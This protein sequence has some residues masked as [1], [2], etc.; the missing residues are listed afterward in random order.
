[1]TLF[2]RWASGRTSS[3]GPIDWCDPQLILKP[4]GTLGVS[5]THHIV[6]SLWSAIL[7]LGFRIIS[8][9][10]WNRANATPNALHTAYHPRGLDAAYVPYAFS[11]A[12]LY[13]RRPSSTAQ[14]PA[15][16]SER[17]E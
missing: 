2:A 5:G 11:R 8:N 12:W 6:F 17:L 16:V 13:G 9:T 14:M 10:V 15:C 1:V 7:R 3:E 4:D